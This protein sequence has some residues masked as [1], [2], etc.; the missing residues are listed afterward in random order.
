MRDDLRVEKEDPGSGFV[1]QLFC[2]PF[3]NHVIEQLK[4]NLH[5]DPEKKVSATH[6]LFVVPGGVELSKKNQ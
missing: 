5:S 3:V 2:C 1:Q 6:I 4:C